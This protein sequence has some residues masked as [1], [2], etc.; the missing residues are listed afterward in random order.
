MD[1]RTRDDTPPPSRG[2]PIDLD[3]RRYLRYT[4]GTLRKIRQEFG[5]KAL[6]EGVTEEK[7]AKVLWYGLVGDDPDL[8]VEAVEEIIDLEHLP[9]V[10]KAM[11]MAMGGKAV[12]TQLDPHEPARSV[13]PVGE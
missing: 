9:E 2:I 12:V 6:S 11:R 8:K 10:T 5:E 4:L 13:E 1:T 3:H 7:L